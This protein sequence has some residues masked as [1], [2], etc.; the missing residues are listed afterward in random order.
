MKDNLFKIY[1]SYVFTYRITR[2][3]NFLN[4]DQLFGEIFSAI[5]MSIGFSEPGS[6]YTYRSADEKR[7][8]NADLIDGMDNFYYMSKGLFSPRARLPKIQSVGPD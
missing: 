5:H 6:P 7:L 1:D 4:E 3:G 8:R 2:L